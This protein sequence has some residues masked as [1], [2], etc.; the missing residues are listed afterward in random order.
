MTIPSTAAPRCYPGRRLIPLGLALAALGVIG[1]AVQ[2]WTQRLTTPWY[3]PALGMVGAVCLVVSLWKK[4]TIWRILALLFVVLLAGFEWTF[5]LATRLPAYTGPVV[6]GQPFPAFATTRSD[7][8]KFT[9]DDLHDGQNHVLVFFR[10][11]W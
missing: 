2:I 8:T 3:M 11:R 4:R 1:Y 7:G 10:G 9:Q 5:L 6:V